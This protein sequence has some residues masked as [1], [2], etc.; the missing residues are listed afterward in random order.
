MKKLFGLGLTL[1][2]SL[3]Y[4]DEAMAGYVRGYY[5]KDGTYVKSY[6]RSNPV[7]GSIYVPTVYTPPTFTPS[8][9]QS[10]KPKEEEVK[11]GGVPYMDLVCNQPLWAEG[12]GLTNECPNKPVFFNK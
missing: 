5:R 9:P 4:T 3:F 12:S 6:Y 10:P 7:R 8:I 1:L 2:V 11:T